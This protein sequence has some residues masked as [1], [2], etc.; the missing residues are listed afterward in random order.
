[1]GAGCGRGLWMSS[2]YACSPGLW[3]GRCLRWQI[4]DRLCDGW[5]PV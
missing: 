5:W 4:T 3:V 1:M 2:S